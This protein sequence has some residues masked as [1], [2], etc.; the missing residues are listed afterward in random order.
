MRASSLSNPDIINLLNC[1]FVPVLYSVD[2]YD[3]HKKD[4]AIHDEW[5]RIRERARSHGLARG[6]VC[7][8]LVDSDGDVLDSLQVDQATQ[9]AKLIPMLRRVID[10]KSLAPRSQ[11]ELRSGNEHKAVKNAQVADRRKLAVWTRNLGPN[12]SLGVAEDR[13]ELKSDD[14]AAFL[15]K[16]N[17]EAGMSWALPRQITDKLYPFFFPP[18]KN[19]DAKN[20]LIIKASLT[21]TATEVTSEQVRLFLRG[22]LEMAHP[23]RALEKPIAPPAK[24]NGHVSAALVGTALFRRDKWAVQSFQMVSEN[25]DYV[26][27]WQGKP[28]QTKFVIAAELEP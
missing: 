11:P 6:S 4:K 28:V 19:Y 2:D 12:W 22:S 17:L 8:Y 14:W 24:T 13:L 10:R 5:D 23:L 20:S 25:A 3:Q 15:P 27:H 7:V 18:I 16:S 9:P 21:A 1:Y 26:W